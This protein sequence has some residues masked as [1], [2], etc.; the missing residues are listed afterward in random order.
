M[1]LLPTAAVIM[2]LSANYRLFFVLVEEIILRF[3]VAKGL[4][5]V[6]RRRSMVVMV[7]RRRPTLLPGHIPLVP[8]R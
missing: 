7:S 5:A 3:T 6:T 4:L 8:R 2:I 1:L